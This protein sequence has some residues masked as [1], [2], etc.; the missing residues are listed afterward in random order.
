MDVPFLI[1]DTMVDPGRL[2]LV[3]ELILEIKEKKIENK[4]KKFSI[5]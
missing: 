2:E 1:E 3:L 4:F 5:V